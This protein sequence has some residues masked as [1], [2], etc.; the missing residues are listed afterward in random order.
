M[1]ATTPE[2]GT[3]A[4]GRRLDRRSTV[5]LGVV[6]CVAAL[7]GCASKP[8]EVGSIAKIKPQSGSNELDVYADTRRQGTTAAPDF[9]GDQLVEVRT[10]RDDPENGQVEMAGATCQLS[11][12]LYSA[13]LTTP[14]LVRVP[15]YRGQSS[16]LSAKCTKSGFAD[17]LVTVE[18][19]DVTRSQRYQSS[20]NGGLAGVAVVAVFDALSDNSK[21]DWRYPPIRVVMGQERPIAANGLR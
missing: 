21:N 16:V 1:A 8:L 5:R 10:Y 12:A 2:P 17:K 9:A 11:A 13:D 6:L 4:F 19:F 20:S 18:A 3:R 15:L 7:A 14:A